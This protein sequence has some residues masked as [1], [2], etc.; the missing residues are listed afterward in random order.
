MS[1]CVH[2]SPDEGLYNKVSQITVG[3]CCLM[4][5]EGYPAQGHEIVRMGYADYISQIRI[6][7]KQSA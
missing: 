4:A 5:L 7:R 6:L 3:D 1:W 2:M